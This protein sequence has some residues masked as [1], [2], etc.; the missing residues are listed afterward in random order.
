MQ[1]Q[2]FA[3]TD[4][5]VSEM[6]LGTMTFADRVDEPLADRI[7][8][9]ALDAGVDFVDTA[10]MYGAGATE[11]LLGKVLQGRRERVFLATKVHAGLDRVSIERSMAESLRRLQTD[12]VDLF[13]LHWPA[14]GMDV[15]DAMAGLAAVVEKGLTRFVGVCNYPAWLVAHSNRIA[16][17]RG[18]P[19]LR[20]NQIAYNL[21]ERG[22]EIEV[23]PQA[24]AERIA[25]T[26]Y[27]PLC[28][29]VLTG[30]YQAGRPLPAGSRGIGDTRV[31]TWVSQH[32]DTLERFGDYCAGERLVPAQAAVSWVRRSR[33][34]TSPIVG[35]SSQEQLD[36]ALAAFEFDL[37][38]EQYR[39]ITAIFAGTE[40]FEEG[41]QRFPGTTYNYPRL[42]REIE[43]VAPVT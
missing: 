27:R 9:S 43:L 23:L 32:G 21:I 1:R 33:G 30:K 41:L 4:V 28:M 19:Q 10:A 37:G 16:A 18:Y 24:Y 11:E 7:V 22:V 25:V 3:D 39:E 20:C 26:A 12:H 17:E 42:R 29:G 36:T 2:P 14:V 6:C 15:D 35:V 5:S 31:A 38:D 13:L 34:V 40:V 8:G